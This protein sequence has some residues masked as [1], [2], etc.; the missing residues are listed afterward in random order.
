MLLLLLHVASGGRRSRRSNDGKPDQ[1]PLP[2]SPPGLPVLGHLLLVGDRPHVSFRDL[3]ATTTQVHGG[4]GLMLLRLGAVRNVVVSTPRAA[5]AV[6]RTHDHAFASRPAS[7]LADDLV[8][9]SS[10][11]AFAPYGEYWRQVRKLVTTHLFTVKKVRSHGHARQDEVRLVVTRLREA[12]AAGAAVDVSETASA[13]ANDVLCRAVCGKFSRAEG[14]NKLFREL[15]HTTTAL[16]AGFNVENYFPWLANLLGGWFLSNKKAR[17]THRRWDELLEEII[18]DHER[19]RSRTSEHAGSDEQEGG[20]S[21]D[22]ID[23]MLSVQ[24]EY[25]ITRDHI[26]AILMDM[27]EAGNATSSSVLEFAMAELM[28]KPHLMTKLQTEVREKTPKGQEMV[29]EE[30]LAS[31]AYLRAV[32]KET[33]RLHP[34]APLLVPHQSMAD[35]EV[36][37]YK[38]PAGTRVII[39]SWAIGRDPGSWEKAEEFMPE[40]FVDGGAAADVDF[41][42]NDFQLIPFGSG[43]RMCPGINFGL[44]TVSVMLANLVYCFDWEL[45]AGMK[46]EDVDMTEVFGLTVHR[47]EKLILVP[48]PY[49]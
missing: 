39:N 4:G 31:M 48:K 9:G 35:C 27:F 2:P 5:Q 49:I 47:K 33:L 3:A 38:I 12:A 7:R 21:E 1:L 24:E 43:R 37:G 19:R 6:L 14:R 11:V 41:R 30:D 28:R 26:K 29:K 25:G 17:E 36:D 20:S 46:E 22:F 18:S 42:G 45:P 16:L 10:N 44:A 13:F 23:V 8:Y 34:P 40:R 32:V 15:N